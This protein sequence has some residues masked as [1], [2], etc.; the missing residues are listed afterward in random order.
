MYIIVSDRGST[1]KVKYA[2][3]KNNLPKTKL[4]G[5]VQARLNNSRPRKTT[6]PKADSDNLRLIQELQMRQVELE[7]QNKEL[8]QARGEMEAALRQYTNLYDFAPMGYFILNRD[9]TIHQANLNAGHLL[10]QD[11]EWLIG[12]H[13][14]QFISAEF[15]PVFNSFLEAIF[16]GRGIGSCEI[17]LQ[18]NKYE[19]IWVRVDATCSDVSF[20]QGTCCIVMSDITEYKR[21]EEALRE[22]ETRYHS[23][24]EDQTE[25]ICRYL[26][27]G[28][29]SFVNEA[30]ARYYDETAERLINTN[31]LPH[32]PEPDMSTVMEKISAIT[33]Q[34]PVVIY[35]HCIIKPDAELRWQRWTHRGVYDVEGKLIEHQ[36][37]GNDITER[38]WAEEKLSRYLSELKVLYDNG[39]AISALL[40]PHEIGR[41]TIATLS[42][43]LSWHH[44]VIRLRRGESDDLELIAF[45]H[46]TLGR[47]HDADTERRLNIISK[48][49]QGLSGWSVQIGQAIR[50]GNVQKYTQYVDTFSGVH[51]G[52]YMPLTVGERVIGCIAV[53]SEAEDAFTEQDERLLATL[54][55]QTAIAFENARLYQNIQQELHE[56]QQA[57]SALAKEKL[58]TETALDSQRDTFFVLEPVSGKAI[59]WNKIFKDIT[60]YTDEEI[61]SLKAPDSYFSRKDLKKLRSSFK[62][63]VRDG[64][65]RT[66][67]TLICKD[68]RRIPT[69]YEV[70]LIQGPTGETSYIIAVGRDITERKQ[71]EEQIRLL[72]KFPA[73]DPNPVLR[74]DRDGTLL[75]INESGLSFLPQWNLQ[76][77]KVVPPILQEAVFQS[78]HNHTTETF[79]IEHGDRL[80]AFYVAPIVSAGYANLY[81]HDIT[82]S[83]QVKELQDAEARYHV[84]FEQSPYGILLADSK[85]GKIIEANE[86]A[87]RQLSYTR[88]EFANMKIFDYDA[89]EMPEQMAQHMQK[90][91]REGSDDYETLHRTKS[92]EIKNVHVWAKTLKMND[93]V[94]LYAI[95]QDITENKQMED[96]NEAYNREIT[97]LEERQRIASDLHDAVSQ[98]LFSARLTADKLLRQSDRQT[99][100]FT[101]SLIDIN[102]LVRSAAG[103]LRLILVELRN[104]ALLNADLSVLLA[105]LIDSGMARTNANL[106]FQCHVDNLTLPSQVK[107][108]FYRIAQE[109][110]SNAIKHGKPTNIKCVL[111]EN[112]QTLEMIV[113]DDGTGFLIDKV[114]DDH[115]GLQI[116]HERADQ[117]GVKLAIDAQPGNGT[118]ITV[119]WE[120]APL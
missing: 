61:A 110:M 38:K 93:R 1:A 82:E 111:C 73:E 117:A 11:R 102:R 86:I 37:V 20:Q 71:A 12:Q 120:K 59:R 42:S 109:A 27:D 44:I 90:I 32:I 9:G 85:T 88:E 78:M 18:K 31:F 98:T 65:G 56:R 13:F 33:P 81:G 19:S 6:I 97:L 66:E 54:A 104:N 118:S 43:N 95:F 63:V 40:E 62:S 53:E 114:S 89:L 55:A 60:G 22:S 79:D 103:E 45:D 21:A 36:A 91:R 15:Y 24:L 72:A 92:G 69:E 25:L 112:Q 49:G 113:Q 87:G 10:G 14:G 46:P 107:L 35:E 74:V 101:R 67:T 75:Y 64:N 52:M 2:M 80:Y 7:A 23:I 116:M 5:Q 108:A 41:K 29:L 28:R 83:R 48:V 4:R 96:A 39:L 84:L 57:E 16:S 70:S 58:F 50:T 8:A 30:Y 106:I 47:Q 51:S 105:N 17:I 100:A 115:F 119:Y 68:G 77:D 26:P 3:E 34:E 99:D 76:V 94:L